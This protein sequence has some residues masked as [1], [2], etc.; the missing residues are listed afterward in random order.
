[1]FPRLWK[2]T[3][4][5]KKSVSPTQQMDCEIAALKGKMQHLKQEIEFESRNFRLRKRRIDPGE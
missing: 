5:E 2:N 1:M 4:K 3:K